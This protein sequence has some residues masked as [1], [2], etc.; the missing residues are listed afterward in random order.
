MKSVIAF[1]TLLPFLLL[2]VSAGRPFAEPPARSD[3]WGFRPASGEILRITPA[4]FVW[5][6]QSG[7]ASYELQYADDPSFRDAVEVKNLRWNVHCPSRVMKPGVWYWRVRCTG[8]DGGT[9]EW[10]SVRKFEIGAGASSN[11]MPPRRDWEARIPAEHPRIFLRPEELPKLRRAAPELLEELTRQCDALLADP[12][13]TAEPP[14]YPDGVKRPSPEW[15]KMW[16][17]NR[18]YVLKTLDGAATLGYGYRITGN[19]KY[20]QLAKKILMECA[21]WDPEGSTGRRYNDEAGM[22]YLSRFSRAYSYVW[23]L[24]SEAE[25][26]E[27]RS[28]IRIRGNEAYRSLYPQLFYRPYQSHANR[29]WHFLGEAGVVFFGEIPEAGDWIDGAMHFYFCVYPVWGDDDGGWH[30]GISY[31]REYL[32][33]FFWWA[34]ILENTFSIDIRRKPFFAQT[35]YYGMYVSVPGTRDGGFGDLSE[36]HRCRHAGTMSVLAS[37]SRNPY[38]QHYADRIGEIMRRTDPAGAA[39]REAIYIDFLR[40]S[41]PS[42]K[43]EPPEALPSSRCFRGNGLAVMNTDLAD[44]KK[45]VQI[46]FKSSPVGTWSHGYDAN[47]SFLLNVFGERMLIRSGR[48]DMYASNFHDNWMW[49]TKSENNI[50]VNGIGQQKHSRDAKGE[51]TRFV[52]GGKLDYAEGEAAGS[53]RGLL[54]SFRRRILFAKPAAILIV[55]TLEAKEPSIFNWHLHALNPFRVEGQRNIMAENGKAACRVEFLWPENLKLRTTDKFDPPL[56]PHLKL[57]QHHLTADTPEKSE[58]ALFIT[59]IRPCRAGSPPSGE[60]R[61]S[62][63][64]GAFRITLAAPEGELNLS[65]DR[66]TGRITAEWQGETLFP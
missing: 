7:A 37:L 44:G 21:K 33:R 64:A 27:C 1:L 6:E 18:L 42:V 46:H 62:E 22:P 10:S 56:P 28:V 60:A 57:V 8:R 39:A 36:N 41:R 12:P 34:D 49:E 29:L 15:V 25:R 30:E 9:S 63:S 55:D 61:M 52:S 58:R 2:N 43:P 13:P 16:W 53:Y 20:G 35:G 54:K 19:R 4:P 59:L 66:A 48:R 47:N 32:D 26:G 40:S 50:T 14:K 3:E 17:G 38:F 65:V 23:D 5:R 31:W 45:N 51:I 24:L 11:P